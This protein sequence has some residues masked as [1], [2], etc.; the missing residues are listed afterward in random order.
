MKKLIIV[1]VAI[2]INSFGVVFAQHEHHQSKESVVTGMLV[3]IICYMHHD[4]KG[5]KHKECAQACA[6]AGV[7]IGLLEDKTNNVYVLTSD[8]DME[9]V[10]KKK[11]E[12]AKIEMQDRVTV[13]GMIHE[14]GG[15]RILMVGSIEKVK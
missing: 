7:P 15:T 11:I 12:P 5:P 14:K 1:T 4:S 2:F 13:K 10:W 8:K 9:D 6:K 3:D